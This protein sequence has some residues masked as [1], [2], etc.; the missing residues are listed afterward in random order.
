MARLPRENV[1][2]LL[3]LVL[4]RW[5]IRSSQLHLIPP[6][7]N[8]PSGKSSLLYKWRVLLEN[9]S[10]VDYVTSVPLMQTDEFGKEGTLNVS[11][12]VSNKVSVLLGNYEP[13]R[14][15]SLPPTTHTVMIDDGMRYGD[16]HCEAMLGTPAY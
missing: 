10:A 11:V 9:N 15:G 5:V 13:L 8:I 4:H 12:V 16:P 3:R 2:F 6:D 14:P 1:D 7:G